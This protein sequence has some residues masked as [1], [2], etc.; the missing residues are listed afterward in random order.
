MKTLYVSDLDG[1][2]MRSSGELSSFTVDT[3]NYL[4]MQ[5]MAF[6]YATARSIESARAITSG[7]NLSLPVVTRNGAV[8]ADNSTGK[9]IRRSIFGKKEIELIKDILP[10]I[11]RYGFVSCFE[12]EKMYRMCLECSH[13]T[14]LEGYIDYYRKDPSLRIVSS[15]DELFKGEPGYVTLIGDRDEIETLYD[16]L[17]EYDNWESV[18]SKDTYRDEYWLEICPKNCTKAKTL[19]RIKEEYGFD[20]L[21]VFGDSVNDKSMFEIA[22]EA[23]AVSNAIDDLKAMATSVIGTNDEDAVAR[24]LTKASQRGVD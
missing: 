18:F 10:E 6:T 12:G 7:L 4:V 19:L 1:T 16:R 14:G 9:H 13:T 24:F 17:K 8:L 5:G 2:F 21:I 3:I 20:K 23:Y 11:G 15:V 22:D